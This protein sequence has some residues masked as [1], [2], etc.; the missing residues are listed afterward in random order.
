MVTAMSELEKRTF[1][2]D[3]EG[4][5][6]VVPKPQPQPQQPQQQPAQQGG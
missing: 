4:R 5:T 3:P 1:T 2:P 6:F